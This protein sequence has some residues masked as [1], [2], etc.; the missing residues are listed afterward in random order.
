M[1]SIVLGTRP[2][3]IKFSPVIRELEKKGIDFSIIHTGQHYSK[4]MD[5]VFFCELGLPE[6]KHNL[7]VGSAPHSVQI[8]NMLLRLD[9]VLKKEAPDLVMVLGDTNSTLAGALA[10]SNL[11]IPIAYVESGLRS[12]DMDMQEERNRLLV[13]QCADLHFAPTETSKR[14]LLAEGVPEKNISVV[15]N[16]IV[17][18]CLQN[19]KLTE[20]KYRKE[21]GGFVLMTAHRAENV[22]NRKRFSEIINGVNSIGARIVYPIHPRA[23]KMLE[24]FKLDPGKIKLMEPMGYLEFLYHLSRARFVIT[25]SGG[26]VEEATC[27]KIPSVCVRDSTDRPE[28]VEA[29]LCVM[30]GADSSAIKRYGKRI[31]EDETF[32]DG[33]KSGE[34]PYGD[35]KAAR[36]VVDALQ[37]RL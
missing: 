23:R 25:D 24:K 16:T 34:N 21:L 32:R 3:I 18:A 4:E 9:K 29:G 1:I 14:N 28:A 33:I 37:S 8:G 15:G 27:L 7:R 10:A 13:T 22:D 20:E 30:A 36:R 31:S 5:E 17:D 11:R 2:E 35:G 12:F 26:V 6:P 19:L